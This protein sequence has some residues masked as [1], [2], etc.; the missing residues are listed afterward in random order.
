MR[1][2][3]E[4]WIKKHPLR[5]IY[6]SFLVLSIAVVYF[7]YIQHQQ[8]LIGDD[9]H[10]HQNRIEGLATSLKQGIV[11]PEVNYFFIGGY[12]YASSLFYSDFYIYFPA[13]LRVLGF[14]LAESFVLFI[15]AINFMTFSI[16]YISGRYMNLSKT[17]SYLFSLLY[18]LSI[19]RLQDIINRQAIGEVLAMSFFPLVLAGIYLLKEGKHQHWFVLTLGMTGV[20]LAHFISLEMMSIFIVLY[21]LFY[22]KT[23]LKKEAII[24]L[25]KAGSLT[26]LFLLFY[27]VPVMEQMKHTTFHVTS[28]PLVLISERSYPIWNLVWN[29]L[30][31]NVFHAPTANIGTILILGLIIYTVALIRDSEQVADRK[32]IFITLLLFFMVTN[33]FPWNWFNHTPLNTIQFPW[34]FLSIISLLLAYIIVNDNLGLFKRLRSQA[35]LILMVIGSVFIYQTACLVTQQK[36]VLTYQQYDKPSSYYIGAGHEYL[37]EEVN[38]SKILKS[39]DRPFKFDSKKG[40]LSRI[41]KSFSSVSFDYDVKNAQEMSVSIPFIYYYGYKVE[42][43]KNGNKIEKDVLMNEDTGLVQI[44]LSGS[45][46][47]TIF[48]QKTLLQKIALWVSLSSVFCYLLW[49]FYKMQK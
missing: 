36:R 16:T 11:M 10:F 4:Y 14:S 13:I 7:I 40:S 48:Y 33:L 35:I 23:F 34:R 8:L 20:G 30:I 38:Y 39:K 2:K 44:N 5:F 41:K 15:I 22:V 49:C 3:I 28:D 25:L 37:P 47:A 46:R 21:I 32:L 17:K 19:Y 9:Y 18:T 26:V 6:G 1:P 45:G 42:L 27:L 12:G 31:S 43:M 29:S 24:S